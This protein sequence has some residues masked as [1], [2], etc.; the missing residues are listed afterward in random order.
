MSSPSTSASEL[1][2]AQVRA[3]VGVVREHPQAT[4]KDV[5]QWAKIANVPLELVG[6]GDLLGLPPDRLPV[7]TP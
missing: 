5:I 4:F 3:F 2:R 6:M 1:R 7:G